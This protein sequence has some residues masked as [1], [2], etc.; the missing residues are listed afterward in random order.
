MIL[1][2]FGII[3]LFRIFKQNRQTYSLSLT[4]FPF[5]TTTGMNTCYLRRLYECCEEI[6]QQELTLQDMQTRILP[7]QSIPLYRLRPAIKLLKKIRQILKI[8]IHIHER[9]AHR[10]MRHQLQEQRAQYGTTINTHWCCRCHGPS[11][12]YD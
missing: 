1:K 6:Q 12:I 5:W 11:C 10:Q 8:T 7:Q 4:M 2:S 3:N 9:D